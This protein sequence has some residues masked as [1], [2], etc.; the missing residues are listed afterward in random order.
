MLLESKN[1]K[2]TQC[3]LS[4]EELEELL[5]RLKSN[6][7]SMNEA[8]AQAG[9]CEK[10]I[11]NYL[12]NGISLKR[13]HG[14]VKPY[15]DETVY[16]IM[17]LLSKNCSQ[18]E[19]CKELGLNKSS[20]SNHCKVLSFVSNKCFV[21]YICLG[22]YDILLE[23]SR[24]N[25]VPILYIKFTINTSYL[26]GDI[27]SKEIV[28]S[29]DKNVEYDIKYGL[30]NTVRDIIMKKASKD[31]F[32]YIPIKPTMRLNETQQIERF[33][34]F[35]ERIINEIDNEEIYSSLKNMVL[36]RTYTWNEVGFSLGSSVGSSFGSSLRGG[37]GNSLG[38]VCRK[39]GS[40]VGS[41]RISVVDSETI[42]RGCSIVDILRLFV[43]YCMKM[44][45]KINNLHYRLG[46]ISK[47]IK[48]VVLIICGII[49]YCSK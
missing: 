41:E 30:G 38:G 10:Q 8:A 43:I 48:I 46:W 3:K 26:I 45:K 9:V 16:K 35:Y 28:K 47:F 14:S 18:A 7:I 21:E 22:G 19:I 44:T 49:E 17:K 1:K 5:E 15:P 32:K 11:N 31:Y 42:N 24:P 2:Y 20:L 12:K 36:E 6:E 37:F 13:G 25:R 4:E 23:L 40:V 34:E 27:F 39:G 33:K 29:L